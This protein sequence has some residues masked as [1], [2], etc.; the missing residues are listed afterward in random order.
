MDNPARPQHRRA[1]IHRNH[2]VGLLDQRQEAWDR[3]F[4]HQV[5]HAWIIAAGRADFFQHPVLQRRPAEQ[6]LGIGE[7]APHRLRH[8]RQQAGGKN[9]DAGVGDASRLWVRLFPGWNSTS[10][11]CNAYPR[12]TAYI[13]AGRRR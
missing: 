12:A 7:F 11:P 4:A 3:Q 8:F 2:A 13:R 1:R 5:A 9:S 10:G 6:Y